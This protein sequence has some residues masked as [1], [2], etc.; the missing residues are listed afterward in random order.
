MPAS[1]SLALGL[2]LGYA[3]DAFV[4]DP[5]RGHPVA[6]FG[7]GAHA[8]EHRMWR[9]DRR[10]GARYA[11]LAVG[12]PALAAALCDA[13]TRRHYGPLARVA[14]TAAATWA[15]LGGR[16]L[17]QEADE[18]HRL[19]AADDLPAA[20][21]RLSHLCSRD[22][23]DLSADE[24]ARAA[25]ESVA[26]NTSDAVTGPL[27]WGAF[28]GPAGIVAY[29][30]ANTLDAM[31]GY[32]NERYANFGWAAARLDDALNVPPARLT[33][34]LTVALAPAVGGHPHDAWRAWWRDAA[35]HPSPNA[36]VVEATAA[37]ALGVRLGG[38]NRYDGRVQDRGELGDGRPVTVTDLPRMKRLSRIVGAGA[39]A[40]SVALALGG[41]R[42]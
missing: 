13:L 2:L 15:A 27:L 21:A 24:I 34:L 39:C 8:L 26:E 20:R 25:A 35:K 7:A 30:C 36:G 33:G 31:V 40:V 32:R 29:R 16:S 1:P 14:L 19:L 41:G 23:T 28:A 37:G 9:D 42:V 3:A 38:A 6:V 18:I 12:A 22:A 17:A 5:R 10:T 4:P 11:A